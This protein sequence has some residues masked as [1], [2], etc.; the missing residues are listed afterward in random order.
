MTGI[1]SSEIKDSMESKTGSRQGPRWLG[2]ARR[3]CAE[4]DFTLIELV[5]VIAILAILMA[6]LL[7]AF[8]NAKKQ[9][10]KV[11][12]LSNVKQIVFGA[13]CYT[14]DYNGY[15]VQAIL[16]WDGNLGAHVD[17]QQVRLC[18]LDR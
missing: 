4:H 6:L 14:A 2:E 1:G 15:A 12:C 5:V 3:L 13:S 7:P 10:E 16:H 11:L 9:G 17:V 8:S 18:Q